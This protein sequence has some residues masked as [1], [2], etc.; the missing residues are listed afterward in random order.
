MKIK[1]INHAESLR[2]SRI[3]LG[4]ECASARWDRVIASI[5]GRWLEVETDF[6]FDNQFNTAPTE[7]HDQ[8]L[9]ISSHY[10]EEI[11]GDARD[12]RE[13]CTY[14]HGNGPAGE[15]CDRC[16]RAESLRPF[17]HFSKKGGRQ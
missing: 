7:G 8:G 13:F 5:A 6:L 4:Q 15:K 14:C 2:R 10:V 9:R 1:I 11:K 16:G 17:R 3:N 12:G